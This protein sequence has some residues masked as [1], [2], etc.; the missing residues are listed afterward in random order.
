MKLE[1]IESRL[2]FYKFCL[3]LK[4]LIT[5]SHLPLSSSNQELVFKPPQCT[6]TITVQD[7]LYSTE[8]LKILD[9]ILGDTVVSVESFGGKAESVPV[10]YRY[11]LN[12]IQLILL[13]YSHISLFFSL[14]FS[15]LF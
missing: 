12:S 7:S 8:V 4:Q 11:K 1:T 9:S 5:P 13:F 3:S 10:E 2:L 15:L 6:L 14:F